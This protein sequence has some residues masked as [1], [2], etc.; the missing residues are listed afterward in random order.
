M[1]SLIKYIYEQL[2]QGN[3]DKLSA[4]INDD[5]IDEI[6]GIIQKHVSSKLDDKTI[7][8]YTQFFTKHGIYNLNWGRNNSAIKQFVRLF[9]ENGNINAL[10]EIINNDGAVSITK[11]KPI[12][13]IF[14]YC[15]LKVDGKIVDWSDEARTISTWINSKSASAGP[16]EMLLKFMLHEGSDKGVGDVGIL[17]NEEME[18]KAATLGAKTP[19]GGHPAGQRGNIKK[20]LYVYQYLNSIFNLDSSEKYAG[21]CIYFQNKNGIAQF[22]DIIKNSSLSETEILYAIV[23]ALCYQYNFIDKIENSKNKLPGISQLY[24][25]V[26]KFIKLDKNQGFEY[27]ELLNLVGCIQLYLYS[28]VENFNYF[29]CILI[30]KNYDNES[31]NNGFYILFKDCQSSNTKLLDFK[32]VTNYFK[33]GSLD[34]TQTTQG[35]TGKIYIKNNN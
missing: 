27:Q 5:N 26:T 2:S 20:T 22:N 24:N 28:I 25:A 34:S 19:S 16:A 4:Y 32:Y 9:N 30:D 6:L 10:N 17:P 13:N 11:L 35:R 3:I 7:E 1:N 33:F 15:K 31:E 8:K 14:N 21:S 12:D 23:D 18:V 29:I